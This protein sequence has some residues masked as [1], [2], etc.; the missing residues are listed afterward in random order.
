MFVQYYFQNRQIIF[1]HILVTNHLNAIFY[2]I[3]Q[4]FAT[5]KQFLYIYW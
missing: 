5:D 2:I 4:E 3:L 1:V